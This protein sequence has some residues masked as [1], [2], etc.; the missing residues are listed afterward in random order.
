[1]DSPVLA[2]QSLKSRIPLTTLAIFLTSL[3]LLSFLATH[4]LRQD[5]ERHL[6]E[7]QL[8]TASYAAT[9]INNK[10]NDRLKALE[11]I[12]RAIDP[13]MLDAPAALQKFIA[14][15]F[16]L[17]SMFNSGL[18][19]TALNGTVI[20]DVPLAASRIGINYLDRPYLVDTLKNGKSS[21]SQPVI[22]K[23]LKQ[24]VFAMAV[25]IRTPQGKVIG[26]LV[27]VVD[28]SLPNFLDSITENTYGKTGGY[29]IVAPQYRLIITG[30]DKRRIMEALP[31]PGIDPTVDRFM[32]GEEGT[33]I[34][35][36]PLGVELLTSHKNIPV[37]GWYV[38]ASLPTRE[39]FAAITDMQHLMLAG[40]LLLTVLV[41]A[42]IWW[43]LRRQLAPIFSTM[44]TLS[45]L[46]DSPHR[47]PPLPITRKDEIGHLIGSFNRLLATLSDRE[48]AL[49][50]NER[51]LS[52]VIEGADQGFWDWNLSSNIFTISPRFETMLGY[53]P[54]EMQ[55]S[56]ENWG[57]YVHPDDLALSMKSI[58]CHMAGESALHHVELRCLTKSGTW[59]WIV[60]RGRIVEH[61]AAGKP[62]M[63][64]G[65][66]TDISQRKQVEEELEH[67][68]QHLEELVAQRT[69]ELATA[70]DVAEAA[71]LAK[72]A[73]LA[74][75]S[76][77]IRTPMNAILGMAHLL[78]RSGITPTQAERLDRIDTAAEHLLSLI[79]DILDLSKIEAG[80]FL[81]EE[82]PLNI[83][84]LLANILSILGE[85]AQDKNITL[86]S[87]AELFPD[88]LHGDAT[89]LQQALLNYATNA[90]KFTEHGVVTLRALRQ[91]E[92]ADDVLVRFEVTDTG[93]GIPLDTQSRLFST[94]EQADNSTTRKYGGTGLGLAITRRL[95]EL[96]G[97]EVGLDSSPGHGSTFWFTA[98][99]KKNV[100]QLRE[101]DV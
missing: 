17:H 65:T 26:A 90:L 99:L 55:L 80:K 36:N 1:M 82:A 39:A 38:A 92:S 29:L 70:R 58:E 42:L 54:G 49:S 61:D 13:T 74:N 62:T 18:F 24:P 44:E 7:Q 22:D 27:G 95:A 94:F 5:M 46:A 59:R 45:A 72:S 68:R 10:L 71:N 12:A 81:L 86:R 85:R 9:E 84:Q 91:E 60:T 37:A 31:A 48:A 19:A 73:F 63:M 15:R 83:K 47:P 33:R 30:S 41:S 21:I 32:A 100:H 53:A 6:G 16:V 50:E 34:F 25:P 57:N 97:G 20:A 8:S 87:E 77:E 76:H 11:Q 98:R 69:E 66:H 2:W 67:Y 52:R 56:P 78:R 88:I 96:M 28:L 51:R 75:M 64:S 79:N 3:W 43:L 89:R 93:I 35:V 101:Q 4:I 23:R 14:Q 40:A